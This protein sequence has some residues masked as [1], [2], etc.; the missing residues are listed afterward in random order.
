MNKH[1]QQSN[2]YSEVVD[3]RVLCQ[4]VNVSICLM[5]ISQISP[6]RSDISWGPW[7][8]DPLMAFASMVPR[9]NLAIEPLQ[10][11]SIAN[12]TITWHSL[13]DLGKIGEVTKQQK[14]NHSIRKGRHT[15]PWQ[16]PKP[17]RVSSRLAVSPGQVLSTLTSGFHKASLAQPVPKPTFLQCT[18]LQGAG[19]RMGRSTSF[20]PCQ[21]FVTFKSWK[22]HGTRHISISTQNPTYY[23]RKFDAFLLHGNNIHIFP[24]RELSFCKRSWSDSAFICWLTADNAI[25][26]WRT[27]TNK[28]SHSGLVF[29][30][31]GSMGLSCFDHCDVLFDFAKFIFHSR[32]NLSDLAP[33]TF[34]NRSKLWVNQIIVANHQKGDQQSKLLGHLA[35]YS[36]GLYSASAIFSCNSHANV[37]CTR[38]LM[39]IQTGLMERRWRYEKHIK[40]WQNHWTIQNREWHRTTK[41]NGKVYLSTPHLFCWNLLEVLP[42]AKLCDSM[43]FCF[44]MKLSFTL[45]KKYAAKLWLI[46]VPRLSQSLNFSGQNCPEFWSHLPLWARWSRHKTDYCT[47]N[48]CLCL[49]SWW[50]TKRHIVP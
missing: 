10:K 5:S 22:L 46:F 45:L 26:D 27:L 32:W 48:K 1:R 29:H 30:G 13:A 34:T 25:M 50:L 35:L 17:C 4:L 36:T 15:A 33:L 6:W 12:N 37:H 7:P 19:Q 38:I 31:S 14:S 11:E 47:C 41:E 23:Y 39:E 21:Q 3:R 49:P 44:Q 9:T 20:S 18:N 2:I 8:F 40:T 43:Q 42:G 24:Q 28:A 16:P